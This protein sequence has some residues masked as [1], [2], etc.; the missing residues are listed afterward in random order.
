M[1]GEATVLVDDPECE[2]RTYMVGSG[3]SART[4]PSACD[5]VLSESEVTDAVN[6]V[7]Q[8]MNACDP[9]YVDARAAV[10]ALLGD[11]ST[12]ELSMLVAVIINNA[13]HLCI[14]TDTITDTIGAIA[15]VNPEAA[16]SIVF[17]AA[18]L[19][20]DNAEKFSIAALEGAPEQ[21]ENIQQAKETA[22]QIKE[23][24]GRD[25]PPSGDTTD[26]AV[27]ELVEEDPAT[28]APE[29][30]TTP[31]VN[32]EAPSGGSIPDPPSPE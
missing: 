31:P 2:T 29:T 18:V 25:A 19:E 24:L 22:D 16:A 27:V 9:D 17:V 6:K 12:S 5:T 21:V 7:V 14:D 26:S 11:L 4:T 10:T 23:D 32:T 28:E 3:H 30:D 15:A 20:P 8:K 13:H 1:I